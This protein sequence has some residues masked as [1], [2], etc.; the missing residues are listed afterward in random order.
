M[1]SDPNKFR[2]FLQMSSE[3]LSK[4]K[5]DKNLF[6]KNHSSVSGDALS[7]VTVEL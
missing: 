2:G 5:S 3:L 4:F 6:D 1:K 7:P